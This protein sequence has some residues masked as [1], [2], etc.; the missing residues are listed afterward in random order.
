MK[1]VLFLSKQF[2]FILIIV[3][4][5]S[6]FS[7]TAQTSGD[8]FR[9]TVKFN[10]SNQLLYDNSIQF[11]YERILKNNRSINV[12]GG[13]QEFP[14]I[15]I[16]FNDV[17][18]KSSSSRSGYSGGA[19]YRFYLTNEN[20]YNAPRG[21]YL[22]P[23]MSFFNFTT[24]RGIEHTN[25]TT[26]QVDNAEL[27]TQINFTNLG[28]ALGYQFVIHRRWVIDCVLFG[29][30]VTYYRFKSKLDGSL[31][32]IDD[33]ELAQK[34]IE[35]LKD[36]LPFLNDVSKGEE[37]TKDGVESITALGFRYNI[38]IGYRF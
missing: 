29:P 35:A 17:E 28:G 30:S 9:N 22:A 1:S 6:F 2:G 18:F 27:K 24:K 33:N 10:V 3:F 15:R 37:V 20:K 16:D 7:A 31:S 32:G 4:A 21:V 8:D 26:G 19:E 34:V 38:S 5:V 11:S 14:L 36:K 13:Y 12:F 25:E 23:F